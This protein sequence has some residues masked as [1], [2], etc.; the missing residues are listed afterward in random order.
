MY[1]GT[2]A[3]THP[4]K[5]AYIM[6]RTGAAVTYREL[7]RASNR[8]ARLFRSLGLRVDDGIALFMENNPWFLQICW[9]AQR[10]GLRYTAISSRLTAP[11]VEH[12]TRDSGAR[13]FITSQAKADVAKELDP[14][15]PDSLI[16]FM[17][18]GTSLGFESW[19]DA[20]T[21]QSP[22]PVPDEVEGGDMLYSSGTTGRPKG[23]RI[24]IEGKSIGDIGPMGALLPGLYGA[25]VDSVYL[26]PA[27]LYHA[28]PLRFTMGF[29]RLGATSIVME[30]FDANESL[31][32]IEKYR[33]THSQ[34]VPTMFVRM[35]KLPEEDRA[36]HDVSSLQVAIHSAAP[37]P[38]HIKQGMIDWWGPVLHEY[39]AGTENNGFTAINSEEWLERRGSVGRSLR[40][41]PHILDEDQNELPPGE[42]GTIY[43][44]GTDPVVYHNDP[45]KSAAAHSRQGW[46]TLDD[47]GYLDQDGYLY[48]TDRKSFMIISGGVNIYPQETEDVL[49]GHPKVADVAVIG[50]PDED[51]GEA[52]K[53]VVEPLDMRDAG[54]ELERE[55]IDYCRGKLS[56]IKTPRSVDF[57]AEL[58]RHPTGKLY[59]RL[60]RDRYWGEKSSRIV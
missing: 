25:S 5:P 41:V 22:Q 14:L 23:V 57:D 34:W 54:P 19:E 17:A 11:E 24:P 12:I 16:R 7:D 21:D 28:A 1:P 43:F 6:A 60:L 3:E 53:A 39:Y 46:S 48:L 13:V 40:G 50:V 51:F 18:G 45:E 38:V 37:C 55:L 27:P 58:P 47:V 36:R 59:K 8:A 9:A 56:R 33:V 2:F 32:L 31:R 30:E 20:V 10:S 26:S 52:V 44:E 15:L 4:D 42:A 35:L 29:Q 49:I